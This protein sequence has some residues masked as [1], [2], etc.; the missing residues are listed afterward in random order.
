MY[1]LIMKIYYVPM[2]CV[3]LCYNYSI[4][5]YISSL[6]QAEQL[7]HRPDLR[8]LAA[9]ICQ[10]S[11][12]SR[13]VHAFV[14]VRSKLNDCRYS[15]IQYLWLPTQGTIE[16]SEFIYFC[17]KS[18]NRKCALMG[19]WKQ[20]VK[21]QSKESCAKNFLVN[22]KSID[23][24]KHRRGSCVTF[25]SVHPQ[26]TISTLLWHLSLFLFT[27]HFCYSCLITAIHTNCIYR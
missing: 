9:R 16:G 10:L 26:L 27:N 13:L 19:A 3:S 21:K 5:S 17:K 12:L 23:I 7:A 1:C 15:S 14:S 2:W 24:V 4:Y 25:K 20:I 11:G 22:S 18:V 6:A 8:Q